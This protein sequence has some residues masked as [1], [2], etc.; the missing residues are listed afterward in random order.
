MAQQQR[1][2]ALPLSLGHIRTQ[3]RGATC[4]PPNRQVVDS[5]PKPRRLIH[6]PT[7]LMGL[8]CNPPRLT[9]LP[10]PSGLSFIC[11]PI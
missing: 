2:A 8:S 9:N 1:Q 3:S 11:P 4:T 7:P 6:L 10:H 5:N